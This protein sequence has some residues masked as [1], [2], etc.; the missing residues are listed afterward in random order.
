VN[1]NSKTSKKNTGIKLEPIPKFDRNIAVVDIYKSSV[2][3]FNRHNNKNI[4]TITTI[5]DELWDKIDDL[6]PHEKPRYTVGRSIIPFRKVLD[7][8]LYVLRT[9]CQWKMLPKEYGPGSTCHRR[10]HQWVQIGIFK[11]IWT[12]LLEEYD[13]KIGIKLIWQSFDS[14]SIKSPLGGGR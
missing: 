5:S 8:I 1:F 7:G 9:G 4:S 11:K 13:I 10:F 14:I 12:K 3:F 2:P 6:L